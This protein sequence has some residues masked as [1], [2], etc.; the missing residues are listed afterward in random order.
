[1]IDGHPENYE[2]C[3]V[4]TQ[5]VEAHDYYRSVLLAADADADA[6]IGESADPLD[7]DM[8]PPGI[9]GYYI[10]G[11]FLYQGRPNS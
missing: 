10:K 1:M 8:M 3:E 4:C 6:L 9:M 5:W 2:H 11:G 7:P